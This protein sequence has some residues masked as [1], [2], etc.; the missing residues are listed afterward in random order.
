[1][2]SRDVTFDVTKL[3]DAIGGEPLAGS[4]LEDEQPEPGFDA[5]ELD[6]EDLTRGG[7]CQ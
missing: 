1:M 5:Q 3:L 7:R 2:T 4:G 6:T